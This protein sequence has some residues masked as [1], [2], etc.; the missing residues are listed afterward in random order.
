MNL[1]S[2]MD[3]VFMFGII[4]RAGQFVLVMPTLEGSCV[5]KEEMWKW[6]IHQSCAVVSM[7]IKV[8]KHNQGN[9]ES[10]NRNVM[11]EADQ[12]EVLFFERS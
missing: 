4:R 9:Y 8:K 11:H 12:S 10:R 2:K 5:R 7:Q 1:L 3:R 6:V